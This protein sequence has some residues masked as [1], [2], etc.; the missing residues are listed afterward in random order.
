[1]IQCGDPTGLGNGGA[2]YYGHYFEDEF[3]RDL[4]HTG[5][6][7]LSIANSG[8]KTNGRQFFITLTPTPWFDNCYTIFVRVTSGMVV[9]RQMA[10]VETDRYE[11]PINDIKI[12]TAYITT[13]I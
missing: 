2:S 3:H 12:K 13:D 4:K 1:M 8:P 9:V 10:L 11:K 6:G 5:A 7:I